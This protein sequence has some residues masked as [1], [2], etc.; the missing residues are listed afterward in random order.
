ML[1]GREPHIQQLWRLFEFPREF[2][3]LS[4]KLAEFGHLCE[5]DTGTPG[6]VLRGVC[7]TG[8][9][10]KVQHPASMLLQPAPGFEAL[11]GA[12]RLFGATDSQLLR[13]MVTPQI[14]RAV[15]TSLFVTGLFRDVMKE[16]E[17]AHIIPRT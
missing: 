11:A 9:S 16:L 12:T 8:V 17:S 6:P 14:P 2:V 7:F 13:H 1:V 10:K 5:T 3:E 15:P 4:A